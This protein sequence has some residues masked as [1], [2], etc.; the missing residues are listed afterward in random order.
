MADVRCAICGKLVKDGEQIMQVESG[1]LVDGQPET[2]KA[3]GLAH[4]SCFN[5]AMPSPKAA[6]DEIRR[7]AKTQAA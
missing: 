7:L 4:R 1:R 5:R 3:W 6:L 2:K